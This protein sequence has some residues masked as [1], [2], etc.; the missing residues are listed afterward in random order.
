MSYAS[1]MEQTT[2]YVEQA[3]LDEARK[4]N[5]ERMEAVQKLASIVAEKH[6]LEEQL[7]DN[8]RRERQAIKAAEKAGW[9]QAQVKRFMKPPK[10]Q[11]PKTEPQNSNTSSHEESS[12]DSARTP[13]MTT[14]HH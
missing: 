13:T 10:K 5:E 2:D 4:V 1:T 8:A 7:K 12:N 14:A 11:Q 9:T 6:E 3:V